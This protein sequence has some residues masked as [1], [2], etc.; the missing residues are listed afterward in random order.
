MKLKSLGY[1]RGA[2]M[3]TA[4]SVVVPGRIPGRCQGVDGLG[5]C[6]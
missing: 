1:S 2:S 3:H 6:L 5:A 4:W